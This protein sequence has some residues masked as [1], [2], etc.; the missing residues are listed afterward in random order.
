M[1]LFDPVSTT[2]AWLRNRLRRLVL[3]AACAVLS[4][5]GSGAP[6]HG[7]AFEFWYGVGYSVHA[8]I[9][10]ACSRFNATQTRD[11]ITCVNLGD[12]QTVLQ[13]TA[14]AYRAGKQP[15]LVQIYD[16]ATIEMIQSGATI[17][18]QRFLARYG[19]EM[20]PFDYPA[21]VLSYYGDVKGS[22]YALP[23]NV[24]TLLLYTN[25]DMLGRAGLH[26][27]PQTWEGF[28]VALHRLKSAG[29]S[30][31]FAFRLEPWWWLEQTGAV[32]GAPFV[33]GGGNGVS[34]ALGGGVHPRMMRDLL[35]WYRQGLA[36]LYG[37]S[38][39]D[40]PQRAFAAQS[41]AMVLESSGSAGTFA[42]TMTAHVSAHPFP[43]FA[44]QTRHN[45]LPG[46]GAIWIMKGQDAKTYRAAAAFLGFVR[47][48]AQQTAFARAT[49]YLP[50]SAAARANMA[51]GDSAALE[52]RA[53]A[54]AVA[55]LNR[56]EEGAS[57]SR[58]LGFYVR[59]R[60]AWTD[61][62]QR[63]F[64]G[65]Q[66]VDAALLRVQSRGNSLLHRFRQVYRLAADK[67]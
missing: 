30:C 59:F 13:R 61:E 37:N 66:T 57:Q 3:A 29:V 28:E 46:G 54:E 16:V 20:T 21:A 12:Y 52:A 50:L 14:A 34:Y 19:Q 2:R 22:L 45:S 6:A 9:Q 25:D 56:S 40:S 64:A 67:D 58:R 1:V 26:Q 35:R 63:A 48:T 17:P 33:A 41:C 44:G 4:A 62:M 42:R 51:S 43:H 47:G 39:L 11:R 27:A 65:E 60:N 5:F 36:D 8:A 55:S 32:N 7:A 15:A 24:S 31:P 10:D 23:Y 38:P 18:A 53:I 49:G